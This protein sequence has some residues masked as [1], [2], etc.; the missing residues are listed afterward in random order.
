MEVVQDAIA[1]VG[2]A[3]AVR[4]DLEAFTE[5]CHKLNLCRNTLSL[6]TMGRNLCESTSYNG[7]IECSPLT[8]S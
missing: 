7:V 4:V 8:D 6:V 5:V 1:V 2:P 3:L